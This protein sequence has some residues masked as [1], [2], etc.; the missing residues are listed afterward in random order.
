MADQHRRIDR[1]LA[2]DYLADLSSRSDADVREM[3]RE[4]AELETEY[5]YLRRLSQARIEILDAERDRRSRGAPLS[6]LIEALPRILADKGAPSPADPARVRVPT[7]LVPTKLDGY[8]RGL[9]RLVEDDTLANL[10]TLTDDELEESLEQLRILEREVS[11]IRRSLHGAIDTL[12][13][14]LAGRTKTA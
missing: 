11:D 12:G 6:E 4:C 3:R 2:P 8:S 14:E 10:P 5:S 1:V 7:Q 13:S 9:E